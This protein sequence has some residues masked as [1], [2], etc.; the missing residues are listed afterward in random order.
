MYNK[1][2]KMSV[3]DFWKMSPTI[4]KYFTVNKSI[5]MVNYQTINKYTVISTQVEIGKT[6]NCV[7]TRRPKGE[8]FSHNFKFSQF[9]RVSKE[10]MFYICFII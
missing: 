2:D 4:N 3:S 10:K 7:E 6:R 5:I 9:P 8:V 1:K